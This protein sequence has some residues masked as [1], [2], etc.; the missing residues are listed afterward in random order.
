MNNNDV[1]LHLSKETYATW[2][3]SLGLS[4]PFLHSQFNNDLTVNLEGSTV[5]REKMSRLAV[6][7]KVYRYDNT[8]A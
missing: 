5:V 8:D 1:F 3:R 2:D 6:R 7:E 4:A